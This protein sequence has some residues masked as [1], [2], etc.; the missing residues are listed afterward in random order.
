[1][2]ESK[3]SCLH[4]CAD[5]DSNGNPRRLYVVLYSGEIDHVFDEGYNGPS[6]LSANYVP[7]IANHLKRVAIDIAISPK[8]YKAWCKRIIR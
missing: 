5:N 7:D 4:L 2:I 1:M 6:V 8:E 3:Y